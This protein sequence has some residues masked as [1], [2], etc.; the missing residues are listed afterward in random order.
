MRAGSFVLTVVMV[1]TLG[2]SGGAQ[3][4]AT[5]IVVVPT[6]TK[7][8]PANTAKQDVN[9]QPPAA[10]KVDLVLSRTNGNKTLSSLPF[11]INV[12][13]SRPT[14]LRLGSQVPIPVSSGGGIQPMQYQSVGSNIDCDLALLADGRYRL[15][16]TLEDSSL[17]DGSGGTTGI[18]GLPVIRSYRISTQLVLRNGETT[19]FNVATDKVSGDTIRAQVT[20]TALK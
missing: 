13:E 14:N 20:V 3:Q 15:G 7:S 11:S 18:N 9:R 10:M 6:E 2:G 16:L 4:S 12:T 8:V 1:L 19:T 5:P 17:A